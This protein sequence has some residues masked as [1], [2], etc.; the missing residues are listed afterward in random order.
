MTLKTKIRGSS[1]VEVLIALAIISVCAVLASG[2]YL[3][4]Q[5]SDRALQ[6]VKA[7]IAAH[8]VL[9]Q[10]LRV[11]E[12]FDSSDKF[13]GFIVKKMISINDEFRDCID[14]RIIVYDR[15]GKRILEEMVTSRNQ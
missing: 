4:V 8:K 3:N 10:T 2:I 5:K 13:D 12:F 11:R 14:L 7:E 15:E 9:E 1:L 6:K